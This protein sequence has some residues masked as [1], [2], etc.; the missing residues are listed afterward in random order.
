M[1]WNFKLLTCAPMSNVK[2]SDDGGATWTAFAEGI[3]WGGRVPF[4]P[5]LSLSSQMAFVGTL[6]VYYL[7]LSNSY[8]I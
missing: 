1:Q 6:T 8:N 7:T 5:S 4:Y 2:V 3:D